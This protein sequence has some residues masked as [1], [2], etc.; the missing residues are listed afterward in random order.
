MTA[1]NGGAPPEDLY[2]LRSRAE[3][4]AAEDSSEMSSSVDPLVTR[5]EK[6]FELEAGADARPRN[7]PP[8]FRVEAMQLC[9]GA[10]GIYAAFLY[11]G[12]LQEDVFRHT[13]ADGTQFTQ[14]WFLSFL[15]SLANVLFGAAA[16][17]VMGLTG[18]YEEGAV[19]TSLESGGVGANDEETSAE[20]A[21]LASGVMDDDPPEGRAV[22]IVGESRRQWCGVFGTRPR[23][24]WGG[25]PNLP[26]R[27]FVVSGLCQQLSKGFTNMALAHGLSFPV[28]TLVKSGKMAPVMAGQLVLG[29][30]SYG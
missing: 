29:G 17:L 27:P 1:S 24:L 2:S 8:A 4:A 26:L 9:F 14:A 25:T 6:P 23:K 12:S 22:G 15:E 18:N 16:L 11:Y 30:A 19:P 13:A 3:N 21:P 7:A 5:S 20:T 28:A 10:G